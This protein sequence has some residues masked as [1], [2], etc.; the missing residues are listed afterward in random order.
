MRRSKHDF[1]KEKLLGVIEKMPAGAKLEPVSKVMDAYGVSQYTI[2]RAYDSLKEMGVIES[3][4]GQG[5]FVIAGKSCKEPSDKL[6]HV[7]MISFGQPHMLDDPGFG[8]ELVH[9]FSEL[10]GRDH[11]AL[12]MTM[13]SADTSQEE[14]IE[15]IDR[16]SPRACILMN[17]FGQEAGN[18]L[19]RR[20]IP[21]VE[22][23]PNSPVAL[24]NSYLIDNARI[25]KLWVEHLTGLGHTRIAQLHGVVDSLYHR[26]MNQRLQYYYEELGRAGI[27]ADPELVLYG[28]WDRV[29]GYEA[30]KTLLSRGKECTA[31]I[32]NDY[33]ASGVYQALDEAG[34]E[35][36]RDM[37]V[38]GCDDVAWARNLHPAL[39]T[40]RI[41][42]RSLAEQ[43]L[44]QLELMICQDECVSNLVTLSVDLVIRESTGSQSG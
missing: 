38:I 17:S 22:L 5:T 6:A 11:C 40:V 25:A 3:R 44:D 18:A 4:A 35:V 34:L 13:L 33:I 27:I 1:L 28:G 2:E 32:I 14:I 36:G 29:S 26:D 16:L 8:M 37:S 31:M 15:H 43:V 30:T 7:D 21:Y 41:P 19:R 9:H 20:R 39:T 10:L 42:R 12:R 24:S 23:F